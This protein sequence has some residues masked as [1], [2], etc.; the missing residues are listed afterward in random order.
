MSEENSNKD[1]STVEEQEDCAVCLQP[2]LYCI[3]L[4][5]HH[6]FCFL[7]AKGFYIRSKSCALCRAPIP[8]DFIK[9][10]SNYVKSANFQENS[11]EPRYGWFYSGR[12]G[13]WQYDE[14]TSEELEKAQI[15]GMSSI[16]VL[17]AGFM[18]KIDLDQMLQYQVD[19]SSRKRSVKRDILNVPK[20]GIAGIPMPSR[21]TSASAS[22][23]APSADNSVQQTTSDS[24]T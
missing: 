24:T 8:D 16:E 15:L 19:G 9:D 20:K 2:H 23:C 7:C 17:I 11:D 12:N 10:P 6:L 13:W 4:P 18:Y 21:D 14:R 3:E 22:G 1:E 5:C